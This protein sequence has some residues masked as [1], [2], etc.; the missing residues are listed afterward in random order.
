MSAAIQ[1]QNQ[2][3][4]LQRQYLPRNQ[5][6]DSR[7]RQQNTNTQIPAMKGFPHQLLSLT[8]DPTL[9]FRKLWAW[10]WSNNASG[11]HIDFDVVAQSNGAEVY[12]QKIQHV[13]APLAAGFWYS[14]IKKG[15]PPNGALEDDIIIYIANTAY[16]VQAFNLNLA[17]DTFFIDLPGAIPEINIPYDAGLIVRSETGI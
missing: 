12:R 8:V 17:A 13:S 5:Y 1:D 11:W 14:G 10:F 15:L 9:A 6:L 7:F 3:T 4:L 16:T 2:P